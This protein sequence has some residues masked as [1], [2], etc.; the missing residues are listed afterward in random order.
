MG[1][2]D[3]EGAPKKQIIAIRPS[4]KMGDILHI[5]WMLHNQCNNRCS[6]C[7]DFNWKGDFKWLKYDHV[8][9]FLEKVF[10]NY[11]KETYHVSFTGGEPTLWPDFAPLCHYLKSKGV[12]IGLTTNGS[13]KPEYWT[14]IAETLNWVCLSY[15][16][17]YTKDEH[18]LKVIKNLANGPLTT[19]RL[20]MHKEKRYWDRCIEFGEKLKTLT[21][22]RFLFVE[23]VPL[24]DDFGL[25]SR[26]TQYE[27]WQSDFFAKGT[28]FEIKTAPELEKLPWPRD[29]WDYYSYY[30]DGS[31][32][33]CRPNDLVARN[34]VNFQGW[35]CNA[36]V[37]L[38]FINSWGLIH[39]GACKEGGEIGNIFDEDLKFPT[40]PIRCTKNFCPC[41]TDILIKK[42]KTT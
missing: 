20:M 1:A 32:E 41:G 21:G 7:R 28:H 31:E 17:E 14:E 6:Y 8:L 26:P 22:V 12:N 16:P 36:G 5:C 10:K 3:I 40:Q 23:Y 27:P 30:N 42:E 34:E 25:E 19:V 33:F 18:L 13:K 4:K 39:R 11:K 24:Q 2:T 15:H 29:M 9:Q 35:T 38:L 37:D